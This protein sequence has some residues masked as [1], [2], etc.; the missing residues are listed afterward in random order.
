[1]GV[2]L[3]YFLLSSIEVTTTFASDEPFVI[4][5]FDKSSGFEGARSDE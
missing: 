4:L 1:M 5:T 3:V 2:A